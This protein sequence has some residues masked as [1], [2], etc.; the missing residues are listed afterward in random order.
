MCK[1]IKKSQIEALENA[2]FQIKIGKKNH[3][4]NGKM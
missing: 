2:L 3:H 1:E 4:N